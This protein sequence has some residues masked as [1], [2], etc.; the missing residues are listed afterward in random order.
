MIGDDGSLQPFAPTVSG[1]AIGSPSVSPSAHPRIRHPV[2]TITDSPA[3]QP[4]HVAPAIPEPVSETASLLAAAAAEGSYPRTWTH[5]LS[6]DAVPFVLSLS[7]SD[8]GG[9]TTFVADGGGSGNVIHIESSV[10]DGKFAGAHGT[11]RI[12]TSNMDQTQTTTTIWSLSR[13]LALMIAR[14]ALLAASRNGLLRTF[15]AAKGLQLGARR[16]VAGETLDD[17]IA[18]VRELNRSRISVAS[19]ILGEEVSQRI[20]DTPRHGRI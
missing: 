4:R 10:R 15:M 2:P 3:P 19:A 18:I 7:R 12:V 9:S 13:H 1:S 20:R 5:A 6:S 11:L 17:F 8:N 14:A 16:F